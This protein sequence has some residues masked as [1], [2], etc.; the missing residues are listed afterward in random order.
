MA[1]LYAA[2]NNHLAQHGPD[3][4]TARVQALASTSINH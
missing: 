4:H 1:G 3:V 2:Q